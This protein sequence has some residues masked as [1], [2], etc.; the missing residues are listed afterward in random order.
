VPINGMDFSELD[1]WTA[2]RVAKSLGYSSILDFFQKIASKFPEE[3][4]CE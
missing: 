3:F 1:L 4:T 2:R